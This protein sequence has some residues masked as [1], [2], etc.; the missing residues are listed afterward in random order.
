MCTM[1]QETI[2]VSRQSKSELVVGV[3]PHKLSATIE[4]VDPGGTKLGTGRYTTEN[5]GYTAMRD[6]VSRLVAGVLVLMV[7]AF[8]VVAAIRP[9]RT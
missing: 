8:G 9:R 2:E 1:R 5:T 6:Y 7:L 3:D 4:V